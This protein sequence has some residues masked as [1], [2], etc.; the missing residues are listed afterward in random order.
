MDST[1]TMNIDRL[2]DDCLMN[3]FEFLPIAD[4]FRA[5][6]VCKRWH[7]I[8]NLLWNSHRRFDINDEYLH[9]GRSKK[10]INYGLLKQIL[11]KCAPHIVDVNLSK[12]P[13]KSQKILFD[14]VICKETVQFGTFDNISQELKRLLLK[15]SNIEEL[16]LDSNMVRIDKAFLSRLLWR[17]RKL[18]FLRIEGYDLRGKGSFR[19]RYNNLE[20]LIILACQVDV[21]FLDLQS[22][23]ESSKMK[24]LC[25]VGVFRGLTE[26]EQILPKN[27][28]Q[29]HLNI[30][31]YYIHIPSVIA[32]TINLRELKILSI[33]H[34]ALND[35]VIGNLTQHCK[36]LMA[37]DLTGCDYVTDV[38]L[39]QLNS[40]LPNLICLNLNW[41]NRFTDAGL[42]NVNK[43][44][45]VL[46][47]V[48]NQFT[49]GCIERVL[50]EAQFLE[51]LDLGKCINVT[52][53]IVRSA[54][55]IMLA[56]AA[57][58]NSTPM[59]IGLY[60]NG[61]RV[62]EIENPCPLLKFSTRNYLGVDYSYFI[63]L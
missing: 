7:Q 31:S 5:E 40:S 23:R 53:K 59:E 32:E 36:N 61:L 52:E 47:A 35:D 9:L 19:I 15:C 10:F 44:L 28:V 27:L 4:R 51:K 1:Y 18:R 39:R 34:P 12:I 3:I 22:L 6:M 2:N 21:G 45:R 49:D 57:N 13:K 48:E 14:P 41:D 17:N 25:L 54:I 37:I 38:G 43:K 56:R 50:Q 63:D 20:T 11:E 8:C 26:V 58:N 60:R 62:A 33:G 16:T 55:N 46:V 42:R 24:N 30:S 29:L